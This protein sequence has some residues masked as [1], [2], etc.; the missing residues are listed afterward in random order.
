MQLSVTNGDIV[1]A[2]GTVPEDAPD[3]PATLTFNSSS[4]RYPLSL[5]SVEDLLFGRSIEICHETVRLWLN[6]FGPMFA[7]EIR[8]MRVDRMR[9]CTHWKWRLDEV[10]VKINAGRAT[11]GAPSITRARRWNPSPQRHGT[12]LRPSNS[13]RKR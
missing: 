9:A 13:S 7:R 1:A 11:S 2:F 10:S 8:R 5:H 6:R 3:L 4:D 12:R